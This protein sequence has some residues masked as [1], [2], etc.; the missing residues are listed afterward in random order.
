MHSTTS[1]D[2]STYVRLTRQ[3]LEKFFLSD[4]QYQ[5]QYQ[6]QYQ[7]STRPNTPVPLF[8]APAHFTTPPIQRIKGVLYKSMNINI[9]I[10][11]KQYVEVRLPHASPVGGG[12]SGV[13]VPLELRALVQAD[14]GG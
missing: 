8:L 1:H 4:V 10:N 9:N 2:V 14:R 11:I 7:S 5:Y 3:E 13:H 12:D 6:Y